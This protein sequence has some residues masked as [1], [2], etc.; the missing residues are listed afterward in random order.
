MCLLSF[1]IIFTN[2]KVSVVI[3]SLSS[4]SMSAILITNQ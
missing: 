1:V 3:I 4:V 2:P